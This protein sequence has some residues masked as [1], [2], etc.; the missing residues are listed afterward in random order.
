[1]GIASAE[2]VHLGLAGLGD[3]DLRWQGDLGDDVALANAA[4]D[5][6]HDRA[7]AAGVHRANL[8]GLAAQLGVLGRDVQLAFAPGVETD[9]AGD[10]QD[11][12]EHG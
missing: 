11:D 3:A 4:A 10:N 8:D 1:M 12:A 9:D 7:D 2:E 5:A 6:R